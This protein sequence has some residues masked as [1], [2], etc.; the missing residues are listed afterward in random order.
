MSLRLLTPQVEDLFRIICD[1]PRKGFIIFITH[2]L[3]VL[4]IAVG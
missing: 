4:A 3:E 2:K 1:L